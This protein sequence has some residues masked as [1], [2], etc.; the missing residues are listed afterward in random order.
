MK[1]ELTL[2]GFAF[3]DWAGAAK[4]VQFTIQ[5]YQKYVWD[6]DIYA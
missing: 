5:T 1:W 6:I 4:N 2:S 3:T